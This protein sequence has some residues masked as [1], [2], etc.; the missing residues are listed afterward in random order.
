ARDAVP[1]VGADARLSALS[2]G[3]LLLD[4]LEG[5]V[6]PAVAPVARDVDTLLEHDEPD[7]VA[8]LGE[9][10]DA[11]LVL[12]LPQVRHG[13]EPLGDELGVPRD[14]RV[15][16]L[17]RDRLLAA[18]VEVDVAQPLDEVVEVRDVAVVE[19]LDVAL[20]DEPG[21]HPV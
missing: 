3:G 5:R 15:A 19:L 10:L 11:T 7:R 13:V 8:P 9:H 4:A 20:A 17:P 6:E 12:G 21:G 18:R 2:A 14:E 16:R 1:D